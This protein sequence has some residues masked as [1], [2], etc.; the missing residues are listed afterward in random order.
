MKKILKV[1]MLSIMFI[2]MLNLFTGLA[3][4]AIPNNDVG[5]AVTQA[6]GGNGGG[7]A[8]DA[9]QFFQADDIQANT[10]GVADNFIVVSVKN[11]T[12][13]LLSIGSSIFFAVLTFHSVFD[14]FS[15]LSPLIGKMVAKIPLQLCSSECIA[16]TGYTPATSG[17]Q[18]GSS[19]PPSPPPSS[20]DG[21]SKTGLSGAIE[22]FKSRFIIV[23]FVTLLWVLICS[24]IY[25]K[26]VFFIVN[27]VA[28]FINGLL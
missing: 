28:N 20:P 11:I 1:F 9:Q 3:V 4:Y 18:A 2:I 22:F 17:G 16:Y 5:Q 14:L 8:I 26:L 19:A 15:I 6:T 7:G 12:G 23:V 27:I 21:K 24:G 10:D 13:W 25:H